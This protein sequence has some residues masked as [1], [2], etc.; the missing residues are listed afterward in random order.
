M[1]YQP[2]LAQEIL[3][4]DLVTLTLDE[5]ITPYEQKLEQSHISESAQK[6]KASEQ[7]INT[8][9][10]LNLKPVFQKEF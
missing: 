5:Q 10:Q 4:F 9:V 2:G 3:D 7:N 6:E 1:K 8:Y